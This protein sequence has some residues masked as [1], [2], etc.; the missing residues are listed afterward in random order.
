[1][2]NNQGSLLTPFHIAIAA[3]DIEEAVE[4]YVGTLFCEVGR[5]DK[6][7]VDFNLFGHQL[8]CHLD[9]SLGVNGQV[10]HSIKAVDSQSVPIPHFGVVLEM[11]DWKALSH[12]LIDK[13]DFVVEP[14]I[15]FAGEAG[16]QATMFFYDPSG[17]ALEFKAFKDIKNQL[18]A[19]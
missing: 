14:Y 11:K 13:V 19:V 7:W 12:S 15:R 18:F 10:M 8:V 17:N 3:R 5:R 1:M 6:E 2:S 16:E 9:P 4:F